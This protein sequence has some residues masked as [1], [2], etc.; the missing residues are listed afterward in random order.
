MLLL[1]QW[2]ENNLTN[3]CIFCTDILMSCLLASW[4][5]ADG[6]DTDVSIR[7]FADVRWVGFLPPLLILVVVVLCL[8][9]CLYQEI[10]MIM[11]DNLVLIIFYKTLKVLGHYKTLYSYQKCLA[12]ISC[13]IWHV[14]TLCTTISVSC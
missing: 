6:I 2:V 9:N 5:Y 8:N 4:Y 12:A 1:I 14:Q 7:M 10:L 3:I 11:L 13:C